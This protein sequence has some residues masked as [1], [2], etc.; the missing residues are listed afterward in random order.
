MVINRTPELVEFA[1]DREEHLITMP[2]VARPCSSSAELIGIVLP[3]GLTPLADGLVGQHDPALSHQFF[4]IAVAEG[5]AIGEPDRVTDDLG[6]KPIALV[7][8]PG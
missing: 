6:G 7:G 4:D 3:K 8:G 1:A 5:E 2:F